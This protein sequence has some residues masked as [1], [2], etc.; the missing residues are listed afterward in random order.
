MKSITFLFAIIM[1]S[2]LS[3]SRVSALDASQTI[4]KVMD[5]V[6]DVLPSSTP[7]PSL[8]PTPSVSVTPTP[9]VTATP[10]P[11]AQPTVTPA[12]TTAPSHDSSDK[13]NSH[14]SS[15]TT[16]TT[17]KDDKES[18]KATE[19]KSVSP[20]EVTPVVQSVA[21][22]SAPQ[23]ISPVTQ[24]TD[25]PIVQQYKRI[26]E[27]SLTYF[28]H[29]TVGNLYLIKSISQTQ[30]LQLEVTALL[31]ILTGSILIYQVK[32]Q[33][34]ITHVLP[35]LTILLIAFQLYTKKIHGLLFHSHDVRHRRSV[36]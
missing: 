36:L 33:E 15:N 23:I 16:N 24:S 29:P 22:K 12:P 18:P 27:P 30:A 6:T 34:F 4:A 3:T 21:F 20:V 19:S 14:D 9:T 5:S 13:P 8:S 35:V 10:T 26:I 25:T 28:M 7:T 31:L 32:R 11:T 17:K 2:F 1:F